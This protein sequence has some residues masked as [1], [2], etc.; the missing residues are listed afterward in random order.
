LKEILL[1]GDICMKG[2]GDPERVEGRKKL[3]QLPWA[4][5]LEDMGRELSLC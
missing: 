1:K 5:R 2:K 3:N 4:R